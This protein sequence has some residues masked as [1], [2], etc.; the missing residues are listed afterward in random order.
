MIYYKID[1]L[2][3][4]KNKGYTVTWIVKNNI[5]N[6]TTMQNIRDNKAINFNNLDTLCELLDMQPGEIIGYIE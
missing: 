5:L 4:L 3:E 2:N 6:S 1:V